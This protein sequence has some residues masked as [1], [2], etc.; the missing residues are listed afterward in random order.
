[1]VKVL[2]V[3]LG[4]ICRSPT[5]E[6]VFAQIAE[7]RG[8]ASSIDIDSAGTGAWHVGKQPDARAIGAA[9]VRGYRL[10]HLR[11]RRVDIEDFER[12]DLILAMD[13]ANLD[14]LL[15]ACPDDLRHKVKLFLSFAQDADFDEVPDPYY[16]GAKGFDLVLDLVE[17]GAHGLIDYLLKERL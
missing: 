14:D 4:N 11:A 5:A 15:E 6:G 17:Q 16:G 3:C 1:M 12:F 7:S 2:F 9:K 8:L 13:K 10:D